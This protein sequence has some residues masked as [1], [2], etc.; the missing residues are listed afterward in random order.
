MGTEASPVAACPISRCH[1]ISQN[2]VCPQSSSF[3][4]SWLRLMPP[5]LSWDHSW[6]ARLTFS[7]A[8]P[9]T[10]QPFL[11]SLQYLMLSLPVSPPSARV[12]FCATSSRH[13]P[14]LPSWPPSQPSPRPCPSLALDSS[15]VPSPAPSFSSSHVSDHGTL[16]FK[17]PWEALSQTRGSSYAFE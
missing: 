10:F 6:K 4:R 11:L 5:P 2:S 16:L 14:S 9:M 8:G 17:K 1:Q 3:P 15:P 12:F 7:L 13:S